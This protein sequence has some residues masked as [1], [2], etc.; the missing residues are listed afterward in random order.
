MGGMKVILT[1]E[2]T[3]FDALASLLAAS[4]LYADAIPVLPRDLNR[5][6]R[7]FLALYRHV[8]PFKTVEELPR[9]RIEKGIFVDT[10]S[11]QLVR[12][13][14]R[15][16]DVL[17][18]DHHPCRKHLPEH[19]HCRHEA[20]GATTTILVE[21]I[22]EQGIPLTGVEATLLMLGIYEDTG[23]LTYFSTTPRDLRCAAWLLDQG[24]K[25]D[26][27]RDFLHHPLSPSQQRLLE[28]LYDAAKV[29]EINGYTVIL[30]TARIEEPVEE[31]STLAHK[32]RDLYDPDALFLL[33]A[34]GDAVQIVARST[35]NNIHVGE[36]AKALGGG[37]HMRAAAALVRNQPVEKLEKRL[38]HLL[39]Q[40]IRPQVTVREIMSWGVNR[41][42]TA[43]TVAEVA[44][45]MATRGHEGFPVVDEAGN[46]QGLV[47]R[48]IIDMA[49]RHNMQQ[50]PVSR[51]MR[52]GAVTVRLNDAIQTVQKKMIASSWGQIPVVDDQGKMVGIVTRTDLLKLWGEE[53]PAAPPRVTEQLASSLPPSLIALLRRS[54]EVAAEMAYPL[55]I[56]GGF[57]RDLLLG[58]PNF[59]LDFVV[60][61]DAVALA[62]H[63]AR[64]FGG[65]VRPH[66]RFGTAKWIRDEEAFSAGR[67]LPDGAPA[68]LDFAT[69]RTEFYESPTALP[70]VER[71]SIK[72]DLHR[73]DFTINTLAIR[74]DGDYW[75]ELLDFYG[76]R[77]DLEAGVIR[78]L[79]SLSFIEDPT[80]ILRAIR[81]EQR[82]GFTI[83]PRT[84]ELMQEAVDMLRRVSGPRI[85]H[86]LE[87]IL[88]EKLPEK[89]LRRL[90]EVG[91][92]REIDPELVWDN[93]LD[94]KFQILR[95]TLAH[96]PEPP[97]AAERLYFALW[98]YDLTPAAHKRILKRLRPASLTDKL[99]RECERLRGRTPS[100]S[101]PRLPD[102]E[103]DRLLSPFSDAALLVAR[104]ACDDPTLRQ[105]LQA[106]QEK[107]KPVRI[108]LSG[109]DLRR[110][111]VKPG[112]IYRQ[113]FQ[114]VRAALLDGRIHTPEEEIALA[115]DILATSSA[116]E[117]ASHS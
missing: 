2:H 100:L 47:T 92:L 112:P 67:P 95:Q 88:Q 7:D 105:R 48:R 68:S 60:E 72:L 57:V 39:E 87:L 12:G 33:V 17:I 62:Q 90:D 54:G 86:E 23:S 45:R 110:W 108:H 22:M 116:E 76:G 37:G 69:A 28:R 16:T 3:D 83:E 13:M 11:A 24:A 46:L 70:T 63:L 101:V 36:I 26:V 66:R 99:I 19:Y 94:E 80:R 14:T 82:F 75:G 9:G 29:H 58:L 81:F 18:I 115:K 113:V 4:K 52:V 32:L 79:H 114:E 64:E 91:V 77:N 59:D 53:T 111:G 27:V 40:K 1:H 85:R 15:K 5:N 50:Q 84:A 102:S 78:V 21:R 65:R 73:R 31:I 96:L 109:E 89:A 97:A 41:V 103:L 30:T 42:T 71:S 25:L 98:L 107:L 20:V 34:T 61:G 117:Q 38:L 56:V 10:Q 55:F 43:T 6:L 44:R 49:M 35:T 104:V 51:V 106:Y 8:L 74:L 93:R